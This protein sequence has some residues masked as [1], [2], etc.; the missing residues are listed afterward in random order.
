MLNTEKISTNKT[1]KYI[2]LSHP[3]P[4]DFLPLKVVF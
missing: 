2:A 1:V 4:R 3:T